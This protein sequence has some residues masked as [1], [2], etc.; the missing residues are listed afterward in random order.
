LAQIVNKM[1]TENKNN[2]DWVWYVIGMLAGMLAVFAV[3]N[4]IGFIFLG[5]IAGL[6]FSAVFLNGIVKGR[7]Y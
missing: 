1:S 4:H 3:T 6:I 2:F 7:Q 5:A